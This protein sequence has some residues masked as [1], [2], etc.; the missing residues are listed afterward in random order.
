M[1][2]LNGAVVLVSRGRPVLNLM[3]DGTCVRG[4]DEGAAYDELRRPVTGAIQVGQERH[5]V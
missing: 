2:C 5:M 3:L 4:L 1:I